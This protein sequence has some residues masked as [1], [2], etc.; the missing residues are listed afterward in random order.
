MEADVAEL[1]VVTVVQ[2][3]PFNSNLV[4]SSTMLFG[5]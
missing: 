3:D 2:L 1:A 4:I 5:I